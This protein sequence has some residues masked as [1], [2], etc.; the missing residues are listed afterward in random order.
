MGI[1]AYEMLT[2]T[3]P[4]HSHDVHDIYNQILSYVDDDNVEKLHYP[5]DIEISDILRDLIDRLVTKVNSRLNYKTIIAH[6]FFQK[7]DWMNLRQQI[8]PII[9]TLNGE[10]D[11]SNF[12]EDVKKSRRNNTFDASPICPIKNVNFSGFDLPFVGFGYIQEEGTNDGIFSTESNSIEVSRLTTQ[13][14]SLQ[15]TIDT[16]MLDIGSLQKNLSEYQKK[17]A[18]AASMEKILDITKEEMNTL[19]EKLKEKIVEIASYRTQIK[20]LKNSLKIE[21]EQRVKNDANIADVLNSTYQK[22][23]RAK[24]QS[25][26]NYEKQISEKKSEVLAIQAKLKICERELKSKSSECG[27]LQ[28]TIDNL[29]EL[30]KS[31]KCQSITEKTDLF[32]KHRE[33][34]VHFEGQLRDIRS[35]LQT[36]TD[37]KHMADDENQRLKGT[38]EETYQKLQ[39]ISDQNAKLNESIVKMTQQLN[40]EI[41]ENRNLRNENSKLLQTTME[42]QN[43]VEDLNSQTYKGCRISDSNEGTTSIYC[44][45]E[46]ISSEIETQLKKDLELAKEGENEQRL[47]ANSL[48]ETV[49]RLEAVIERVGKQGISGVEVLLERKNEKLEEKLSTVQE[50]ATI[51]KQASR[52]AHLQL[53]KSEK[54]LDTIKNEKRRLEQDVKKLQN[55]VDDLMRKVKENKIIAQNREERIKELQNDLSTRKSELQTERSRWVAVE[56]ERN[57]E[58]IQIVN[59]N[60]KI[61]KL[62][63]DLD[64][65]TSKMGLLEQQK[66]AFTIENQQLIQK[67][68][69]E[70]EKVNEI[71]EKLTECQ[72]SFETINKNYD[73]LKSVCSLMETQLTELEDM[74]NVQLEQNKEKS[75]TIDKLWGDI[76]ERDS[77]LLKLQREI[78]DEKIQKVDIKQKSTELSNEVAE[79][80]ST[81][82]EYQQKITTIQQELIVKTECLIKSEEMLEL[83]KEDIQSL[84]RINRSLDREVIIVKEENSKLLT[85]LYISRESY[86]KL[87]IDYSTILENYNDLKK[88]LEQLNG[89]VSELNRYHMQREMKSEATQAQYKKLIDYLQKRVDELSQKKKKTLTEVFFGSNSGN[90]SSKKE[91]IPPIISTDRLRIGERSQSAKITKTNT[92]SGITKKKEEKTEEQPTTVKEFPPSIS[93]SDTHLFERTTYLNGSD[94]AEQC[95]VCKKFFVNDTIYQC[96]KCNTCVHQYC[97]GS[98]S[99]KCNLKKLNSDPP[100]KEYIGEIVM[101][102]DPA[103]EIFCMYEIAQNILIM[104]KETYYLHKIYFL[105]NFYF[106]LFPSRL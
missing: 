66:N 62:E 77:K 86:Q 89:T 26:Q 75:V 83:Q 92:S 15:K 51:E 17:S 13:V 80:T 10:D 71:S 61:H 33:S 41:D 78:S 99:L 63:I 50:Q 72:Q 69:K 38:I 64:E 25:E 2:E 5:E 58:K 29:T 93:N 57:K 23:E 95:I 106:L 81:L 101:K 4:F 55:E 27:H 60:T 35:K 1:I 19:K 90:N 76:R 22:W 43:K 21:E 39:M 97:R 105:S 104:G 49:R 40:K 65:C 74:Y 8:P 85:E 56:K 84:Q 16:Q 18:Q 88:E 103:L 52:T 24:K 7:I 47:R 91:N 73:V 32:R 102:N 28:A 79:L 48:E 98:N 37:A 31:S 3:T 53:W 44:S 30:A 100:Q 59:Q 34:N 9:P 70:S 67:L 36:Q 87:Q 94:M 14:K 46:S 12:E 45:L 11:T 96:K 54:E 20:T 68:R 82:N 6:K 42:L